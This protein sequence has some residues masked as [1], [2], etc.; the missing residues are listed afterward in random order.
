MKHS[1]CCFDKGAEDDSGREL[2]RQQ[3]QESI[4]TVVLYGPDDKTTTKIAAGVIL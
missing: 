3:P 2:D 4:G 1:N